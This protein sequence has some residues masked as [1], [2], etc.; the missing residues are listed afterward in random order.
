MPS[1]Y[2]S[3]DG[4]SSQYEWIDLVA[5]QGTSLSRTSGADGGYYNGTAIEGNVVTGNT[6]TISLSAGF[7][8]TA[9]SE[10]WKFYAD[11]NRDG[12]FSDAGEDLGG[13]STSNGNT[14]TMS[15]TVPASASLGDTR[16]RAVMRWNTAAVAC[17]NS[18]YG[19]VEDFTLNVCDAG[20]TSHTQ[21]AGGSTLGQSVVTNRMNLYPNPAEGVLNIDV[22]R[23][24]DNAEIHIT[25]LTGRTLYSAP[26]RVTGMSVDISNLQ[27]GMYLIRVS[28]GEEILT[29]SFYKK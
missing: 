6:Y 25:D 16:F 21:F 24:A 26:A 12:D 13:G 1:G 20:T 22:A 8:G 27:A 7:A 11:W 4:G 9:Y 14:F 17:G 23:L 3:A 29:K 18:S 28:T 19:E 2:C 5:I 10:N 15:M